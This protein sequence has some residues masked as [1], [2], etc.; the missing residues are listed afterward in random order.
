MRKARYHCA[1]MSKTTAVT[2]HTPAGT[3]ANR[4][5]D[6]ILG[7][8]GRVP[9]SREHR[10]ADPAIEARRVSRVAARKAAMMA[11]GLALPPGPLGWLT[12]LPELLTVWKVQSQMVADIA[13][14]Y[15]SNARMTREQ[16]LYCLFRHTAAQAVR[17]M[18]VRMGERIIVRRATSSA[19]QAAAR[20]VGVSLTKHVFGSG[21]SRWLPVV[22]A[23]G[24]GAYAYWDTLKV[25]KTAVEMF[26]SGFE[27]EVEGDATIERQPARQHIDET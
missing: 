15:G 13:A 6:A 17:D 11:G 14:V 3:P 20:R 9:K 23:V 19:F 5:G 21:V 2:P 27:I 12:V 18:V 7:F 8:I 22:G 16:M 24:V 25:A 4:I 26:G 10:R 1:M